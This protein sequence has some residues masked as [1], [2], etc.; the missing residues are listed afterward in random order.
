MKVS[1]N[2]LII[3]IILTLTGALMP[4]VAFSQSTISGTVTE[5]NGTPILGANIYLDGTYDGTSSDENGNFSFN[6]SEE[7][8][9]TLVVSFLSFENYKLTVLVSEM[10]S[11][12]VK[13]REDVNSLDTVVISA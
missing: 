7:G 12:Q 4:F 5:A 2:Q 1:K 6:T 13:L 10:K 11:L 8:E 3:I 9:Q